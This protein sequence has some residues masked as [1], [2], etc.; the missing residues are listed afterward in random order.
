M[1]L[2]LHF[3]Y[4]G[5]RHALHKFLL[6][7]KL[8][9]ILITTAILQVSASTYAQKITLNKTNMPLEKVM[10]EIR[11]QS[12]YDFFYDLKLIKKTNLVSIN[13][14]D[15][16]LE[17]VLDKCFANQPLTYKIGDKVV[18]IKE[19]EK[20]F[21]EKAMDRFQTIDVTGKIVDEKKQPIAGASVKIMGTLIYTST[22]NDGN[23]VLKNV[24]DSASLEISS[25][26]YKSREIKA[27]KYLGIVEMQIVVGELDEVNIISTGYQILKRERTTG[28]FTHID[29]KL[30][31][32]AVST[33]VL[34]RIKDIAPGIY[35][36]NRDPQLKAIAN[37]P[38][39]RN[40]GITIRGESTFNASKQ[41]LIILDNFPYDGE[42][43]NINPNDIESITI[44][45]DASAASIWGA[46]SGNG[47]I[48][49]TSKK[50]KLNQKMKVDFNSNVT[51]INKPDLKYSSNFLNSENYIE[52]EQFLFDQGY[53]DEQLNDVFSFPNVSPA[54][55]LMA[56]YKNATTNDE[57][58]QLQTKL[59]VLKMNDVRD[60]YSKYAYQKAINQQYSIGIRGGT[61]NTSYTLS[62]GHDNN[63]NNLIRNGYSRTSLN[64]I[65]TYQPIKNLELTAGINYSQST[66]TLNNDLSYGGYFGIGYPYYSIYPYAKLSDDQGNSLPLSSGIR[67][68]YL[69]SVKS[70]GFLDWNYRPLD[71]IK[72]ADNHTKVTDLLLRFQAKYQIIKP[73]S[74]QINYQNERQLITGRNYHSLDTYYTRNLINRFSA[75]NGSTSVITYNLPKGGIL[76][77]SN[78]DWFANTF[79]SQFNYDYSFGKHAFNAVGGAEIK[80]LNTEGYN[81]TSYGY[82]EQ[83]GTAV[84]NLNYGISYPVNPGGS[85]QI[86]APSGAV[87]GFLNRNLSYYAIGNYT[88]D[89]RYTLNLSGRK[90]GANLFGAAVNDKIKPFLSAGLGWNLSKEPFYHLNWLPYIRLRATYGYQGNTYEAGSSYLTGSYGND[91][92]TGASRININSAPNPRLQ[93]EQV[94]NINLGIDLATKNNKINATIE[95]YKKNG[96]NLIQPTI[97]APQTGFTTYL[98]NTANTQTYGFDVSLESKN[99][100]GNFK[101]GTTLLISGIRDKVIKYDAPLNSA[102]IS[103]YSSRSVGKPLYA[104]FSYKWAGLNPENGNPRGYING[105]ISEDYTAIIN[106]FNPDSLVYNGSQIPTVYGAFRNDFFYKGFS[107]SVNISYR[108]G[109][110]FRR[111]ST[112]INYTDI[113]QSGQH[114]DYQLRWQKS[115][116]ESRTNIPSLVY[117][118]DYD[119]NTFF[120][121]SATLIE[122]GDHIRLQDIKLGYTLPQSMTSKIHLSSLTL[123]SY[124]NN[125]G[126]IWRKNKLG[127]D[128]SAVGTYLGYPSQLSI[129]FG[130]QANF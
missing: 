19:K 94:R 48:V 95:L 5:N 46:R 13:V 129:S 72:L 38:R 104:L 107:L 80:Q 44:L 84:S 117:P 11:L 68:S 39:D 77:I 29:N 123:F 53:F 78:T 93:W 116:D 102:S 64:A 92:S 105:H 126:V 59:N 16:S 71:E 45:K 51:L 4:G 103:S 79:R 3:K 113:I 122:S 8:I 52:T 100:N 127:I 40:S 111:T 36:E 74:F 30:L 82:S 67:T 28:S 49:I 47:V 99:L 75:Y 58:S 97:L 56:Q 17:E 125:L 110:V 37:Y 60:D 21:F 118:A 20:S 42:I 62:V 87:F 109:Y 54:V 69:Q 15:A 31:N 108:L 124:A 91:S 86:P 81:R 33:N 70:K 7:M 35:F 9:V 34:D 83:F 10:K 27:S 90:D 63:K 115:G 6:A 55:E 2:N 66:T 73:L 76:D 98:A 65:N 96:K 14:K 1:N 25:I 22:D 121:N 26:G 23:F 106:N 18:M 114:S 57:R 43:T 50:G 119:R 101:W 41:P 24:P 88:Y 130:I 120:Q 12:G 61:N 128:P 112:N 89:E 85:A 32:R